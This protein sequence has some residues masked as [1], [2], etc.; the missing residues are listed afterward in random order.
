MQDRICRIDET[1]CNARPDHTFATEMGYP[2]DVRFSPE[3]DR[4]AGTPDR[5]LRAQAVWKR[6]SYPNNCK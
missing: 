5:Q 2:R 4:I 6:F 1:S 3:S